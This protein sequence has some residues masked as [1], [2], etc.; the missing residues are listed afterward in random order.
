MDFTLT[1]E[2]ELVVQMVR[3]F[4]EKEYAPITAE[5]DATGVFPIDAFKKLGKYGVV[6]LPFPKEYGGSG[7]DY[8]SYILAV[9]EISKECGSTGIS[10]SVHTSLCAGAIY[11]YANEEQKKKYLPDLASG[12]KIGSFGLTE[13]SAGTDAA[14]AQTVAVKEGDHYVLNGQKCFITNSPIADTFVIFAK[15]DRHAGVKGISAFIVEKD[16]PGIS[17]GKIEDK[18]GIRASQVGEI[19]FEDCIVPAENLMGKEGQGFKIAMGTLD[20]GRI[21]VA[22]QGLGI[23]E[24]AF[25]VVK[26]YM[27]ERKQFGKSLS[28]FQGLQWMMADM[29]LKI[30]QAR[31]LVYKAAMDKELNKPYGVSAARAKLAATDAAMSITTD[32]IQLMGGYGFMKDYPLERMM[33]DAKI[34]QIYEGTNQVMKM[35][36]AGNIFR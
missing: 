14:G 6:G 2:Q 36:I 8:L 7:G 9:E 15:T 17:I 31:H 4:T 1:K 13:P 32:A 3:E 10:F 22:A 16:F 33:R 35:V 29:D 12:R 24:G 28:K 34:T 23:A 20:G 21:G 30:E 19:I 18:M 26:E 5:C 27:K 25:N 11:K